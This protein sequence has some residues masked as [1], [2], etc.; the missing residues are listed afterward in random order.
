MV[1]TRVV[2]FISSIAR[3]MKAGIMRLTA[4]GRMMRR[5]AWSGV[6]PTARAASHWPR[7]IDW[8]PARKTSAKNAADWIEKVTQAARNGV[9]SMP[10]I[11]G[12]AKKNQKSWTSGGGGG[13]NSG[14]EAGGQGKRPVGDPRKHGH[15]RAEHKPE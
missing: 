7:S 8:M 6:M 14:A 2:V 12:R 10:T 4:C 3:S 15:G 1:A 13:K 5:S 9:I 11:S